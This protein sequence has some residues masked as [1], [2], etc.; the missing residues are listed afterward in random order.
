[1]SAIGD[2]IHAT[3]LGYSGYGV[4]RGPYY[5][6]GVQGIIRNRET[7]L[8]KWN[9]QRIITP[10]V[11]TE[12]QNKI[13]ANLDLLDSLSKSGSDSVEENKQAELF[14]DDFKDELI[15]EF[16]EHLSRIDIGAYKSSGNII[17][18]STSWEAGQKA[19]YESDK[20]LNEVAKKTRQL[21]DDIGRTLQDIAKDSNLTVERIQVRLDNL[22]GK[23]NELITE[24]QSRNWT[25][26]RAR[27]LT[28]AINSY[29]SEIKKYIGNNKVLKQGNAMGKVNKLIKEYVNA[30]RKRDLSSNLSGIS[31]EVLTKLS[32]MQV[33]SIAQGKIGEMI[34]EIVRRCEKS[35]IN[36]KFIF[37]FCRYKKFKRR[38]KI[39]TCK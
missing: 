15:K 28:A 24:L 6:E 33:E 17:Q 35:K 7:N 34:G 30:I 16:G 19:Y 38:K 14:F 39:S 25:Q 18:G 36:Y 1:M 9:S 20:W 37:W 5:D 8:E 13:E 31:G 4:K 11:K 21:T 27:R 29:F 10:S 12:L 32:A 26:G 3:S 22:Q 2:Y 23:E